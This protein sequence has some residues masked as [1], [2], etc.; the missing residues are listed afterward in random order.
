MRYSIRTVGPLPPDEDIE[1]VIDLEEAK[2]HLNVDHDA[3]DALIVAQV[4]AAQDFVEQ[5]TSRI[6]TPRVMEM[7]FDGFP[8]PPGEILLPR[9]PV[10][11]V[12][13]LIYTDPEGVAQ[14]L[15]NAD[16]RWDEFEPGLVRPAFG[17]SWPSAAEERGSFRLQFEAGYDIGLAPASLVAAVKLLLGTLYGQRESVVVGPIV[18]DLPGGVAALCR[19]Y[20]RLGISC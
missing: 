1:G 16:W 10:T 11:G 6:L 3:D 14:T 15:D 4:L 12:L 2:Q 13:S 9:E 7:S 5:F 20:R 19:P 17:T 8:G 18:N